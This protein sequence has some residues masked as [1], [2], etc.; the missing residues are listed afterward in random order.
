[1]IF[2]WI[3]MLGRFPMTLRNYVTKQYDVEIQ[4]LMLEVMSHYFGK[5]LISC[6]PVVEIIVMKDFD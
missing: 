3:V 2:Y 1:M 5:T 4:I 6:L